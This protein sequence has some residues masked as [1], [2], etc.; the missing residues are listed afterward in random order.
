MNTESEHNFFRFENQDLIDDIVFEPSFENIRNIQVQDDTLE[1]PSFPSRA[2]SVF[3]RQ[4][5]SNI[6]VSRSNN[7]SNISNNRSQ[8]SVRILPPRRQQ[9]QLIRRPRYQHNILNDF[10]F[11]VPPPYVR[12]VNDGRG[13]YR[14]LGVDAEGNPRRRIL[15]GY[16]NRVR[17]IIT[18]KKLWCDLFNNYTVDELTNLYVA[19]QSLRRRNPARYNAPVWPYLFQ[20]LSNQERQQ[21]NN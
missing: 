14:D 11:R 5:R 16:K 20:R 6:S 2:F 17:Q 10:V 9:R 4:S 8:R 18:K 3:G 15:G 21:N 13:G 7:R 1:L 19:Y 12:P